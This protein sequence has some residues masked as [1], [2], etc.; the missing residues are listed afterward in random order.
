[1]LILAINYHRRSH[2]Y[3][4]PHKVCIV[5]QREVGVDTDDW[6]IALKKYF[7]AGSDVILLGEIRDREKWSFGGI[8]RN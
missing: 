8:C 3:V 5:M 7:E 2:Q 6:D 4:H 1:M